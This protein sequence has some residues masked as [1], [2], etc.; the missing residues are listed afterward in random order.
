[1]TEPSISQQGDDQLLVQLPGVT[2]VDKAKAIMGSPGL[3][4]LKIVEQGPV[5]TGESLMV[6]GQVPSGMEI[7]PGSSGKPVGFLMYPQAETA[8][9]RLDSL[10]ADTFKYE[11][12]S[13]ETTSTSG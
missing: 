6:G 11:I 2:D 7:V 8:D 12:T 4:E 13:K 10:D 9:G 3:L 1:M 5:A